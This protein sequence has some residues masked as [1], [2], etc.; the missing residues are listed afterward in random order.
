MNYYNFNANE[1][2]RED[3]NNLFIKNNERFRE[4]RIKFTYFIK[5]YNIFE[6]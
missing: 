4:F 1:C 5:Y 6:F 2:A 3:Y